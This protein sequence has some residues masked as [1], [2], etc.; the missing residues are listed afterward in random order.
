MNSPKR[1]FLLAA[2]LAIAVAAVALAGISWKERADDICRK[3]VPAMA[4]GYTIEWKWDELAYVCDYQAPAKPPRRVGVLDA[5]HSG[6]Q[7]HGR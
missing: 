7:R 4:G 6:G 1:W 2:S 3:D 5:F